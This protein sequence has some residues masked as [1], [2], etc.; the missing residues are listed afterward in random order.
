[1]FNFGQ[2]KVGMKVT[3][4]IK[5]RR[6]NVVRVECDAHNFM[7]HTLECPIGTVD[8]SKLESLLAR[9]PVEKVISDIDKEGIPADL[10]TPEVT[11][12]K[13]SVRA[14]H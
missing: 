6:G 5:T 4:P 11:F 13:H 10:V 12:R 1:M 2:P 8:M 3:K 14:I 7:L 9:T